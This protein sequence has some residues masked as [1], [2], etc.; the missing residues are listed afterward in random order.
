MDSFFL[1]IF[2]DIDLC[3]I[4]FD[5]TVVDLMPFL[6]PLPEFALFVNCIEV[7]YALFINLLSP[8]LHSFIDWTVFCAAVA[9]VFVFFCMAF[10][11][12]LVLAAVVFDGAFW[13]LFRLSRLLVY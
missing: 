8:L 12:T 11:S 7:I 1:S 2:P 9:S 13:V 5:L 3:L 6:V 4:V 10:L